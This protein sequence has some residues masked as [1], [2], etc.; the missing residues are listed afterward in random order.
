[1]RRIVSFVIFTFFFAIPLVIVSCGEK[2]FIVEKD[3]MLIYDEDNNFTWI[4][5]EFNGKYGICE[6]EGKVI[7]T[8]MYDQISY[9]KDGSFL[10]MEKE[11]EGNKIIEIFND[12]FDCIIPEGIRLLN[13]T[14]KTIKDSNRFYYNVEFLSDDGD[15]LIGACD[16]NWMFAVSPV[17]KSKY[18][19]KYHIFGNEQDSERVELFELDTHINNK[20]V[21]IYLF[22][23]IDNTGKVQKVGNKGTLLYRVKSKYDNFE[24]TERHYTSVSFCQ[25]YVLINPAVFFYYKELEGIKIYQHK[26]ANYDQSTFIFV[27]DDYNIREFSAS[28]LEK[29]LEGNGVESLLYEKALNSDGDNYSANIY[30]EYKASQERFAF[31]LGKAFMDK[32]ILSDEELLIKE[33]MKEYANKHFWE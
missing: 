31:L 18:S 5:F 30:E 7:V 1:M 13:Y 3:D 10:K 14:K 6:S 26:L 19:V 28:S 24:V 33:E 29:I 4:A 12:S 9:D 16:K 23:N 20:W 17:P 15:T 21:N 11:F 2:E 8:P 22:T 27:D 25:D 32:E